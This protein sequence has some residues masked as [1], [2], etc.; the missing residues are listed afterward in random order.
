MKIVVRNLVKIF[1]VGSIFSLKKLTAVDNVSFDILPGEIFSLVGESG[2]GK[3]TTAKILLGL[4]EPTAGEIFY[5]ETPLEDFIRDKKEFLKKVQLIQQNPF[6]TFNPFRK[7]EDYLFKT[8]LRF[9]IADSREKAEKII[10]EKL[11][12]VGMSFGEVRDRYPNE[13]SGGQLQRISIARA[14][15]TNPSFLVADEPVSMVDASLR[16]SIVNLFKD[17]RE[18]FGISVLYITHDLSTTYYVADRIAVMF[19]GNIVEM[20]NTQEVLDNP[21]HPY[22]VL[23]KVSVPIPNPETSWDERVDLS[24]LE[25]EE[26]FTKGCKFAGRCP[27]VK[28]ICK[29]LQPPDI[30]C[31]GRTVKCW[32]YK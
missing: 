14:L 27:H 21:L 12:I 5:D 29:R 9:G 30:E 4:E 32:L 20:G 18:R 1:K 2:C 17:L 19:R 26:Y 3:T 24:T 15:L 13:F 11:S 22:T 31:G 28:E 10:D 23:L 6:S 16:I 8:V 25:R 7:I